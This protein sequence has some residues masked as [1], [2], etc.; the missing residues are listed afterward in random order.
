[1]RVPAAEISDGSVVSISRAVPSK[2]A[3]QNPLGASRS[4]VAPHVSQTFV[5]DGARI[6]LGS[7]SFP[8][9]RKYRTKSAQL[10][11]DFVRRADCLE[12]FAAK[13]VGKL[14]SQPVNQSLHCSNPH[15]QTARPRL[16]SRYRVFRRRERVLAPRTLPLSHSQ[17]SLLGRLQARDP[18]EGR[19]TGHRAIRPDSVPQPCPGDEA[20][21]LPTRPRKSSGNSLRA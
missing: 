21:R 20:L 3:G 10:I 14:A 13:R 18:G 19:P 12:D 9:A 4:R 5:V 16:R 1:M 7:S 17:Q 8:R 15:A 2:H 11:I 6:L